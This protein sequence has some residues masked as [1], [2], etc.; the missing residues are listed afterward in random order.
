MFFFYNKTT[1]GVLFHLGLPN[2]EAQL[3][4]GVELASFTLKKKLRI[5]L[6]KMY[7]SH[8]SRTVEAT[9]WLNHRHGY[10]IFSRDSYLLIKLLIFWLNW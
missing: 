2:S 5:I 7:N 4:N 10:L 6:K 8:G 9:C 1:I 3:Q